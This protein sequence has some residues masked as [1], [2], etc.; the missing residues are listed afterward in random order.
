MKY[1]L[2][3]LFILA[4]IF[5]LL[6]SLSPER[7]KRVATA[8]LCLVLATHL[9]SPLGALIGDIGNIKPPEFSEEEQ[10]GSYI[11]A[12]KSAFEEG[13]R[14]YLSAEFSIGREYIEVEAVSFDFSSMTAKKIL[15][16]LKGRGAILDTKKVK[17]RLEEQS[18]GEVEVKIEI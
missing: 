10:E 17:A 1:Y 4:L 16:T 18:L 12:A 14:A 7:Y 5:G 2:F 6:I 15:V 13:V 9:L 8:A 11:E 3:D